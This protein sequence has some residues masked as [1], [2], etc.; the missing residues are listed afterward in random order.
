MIIKG[1]PDWDKGVPRA[2]QLCENYKLPL[3]IM[4]ETEVRSLLNIEQT[5]KD[6]ISRFEDHFKGDDFEFLGT[7]L[8]RLALSKV[9][10]E[11]NTPY[12]CTGLNLEDLH[13]EALSRISRQ[14]NLKPL[15]KRQIGPHCLLFP[16]W[17]CPKKIID[18]CFPKYSLENYEARYPCFSLG[19]TAYY[20]MTYAMQSQFPGMVEQQ[21]KGFANLVKN[22]NHQYIMDKELGFLVEAEIPFPLKQKFLKML[23]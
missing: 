23:R 10:T 5:G 15:P 14:K 20:Q 3:Q 7:L 8:I 16:L 13:S 17:L 19:R 2:V 21:M 22:D 9:A 6:L 12:I 18:G 4:E 11:L 1:I